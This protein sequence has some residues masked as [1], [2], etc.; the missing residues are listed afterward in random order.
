MEYKRLSF[1][2]AGSIDGSLCD[3]ILELGAASVSID[4]VDK[5][6]PWF[7]EYDVPFWEDIPDVHVTCLLDQ[8]I[9][10]ESFLQSVLDVVQWDKK[11]YYA[12]EPVI[13][14]SWEKI[15]RDDFDP[16]KINPS[17]WIVPTWHEPVDIQAVNIRLDPGLAF[18]SGSHATTRLCLQWLSENNL[19]DTHVLDFGCGSG[20]LAIASAMLGAHSVTATDTDDQAITS[21]KDNADL[22][23][24]CVTVIDDPN[25]VTAHFDIILANI[26]ARPLIAL[27]NRITELTR[28]GGRIVLSGIMQNQ[29]EDVRSAYDSMFNFDPLVV[30]G[31]WVLLSGINNVST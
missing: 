4:A 29:V 1:I 14:Q 8:N 24:V 3:L 25:I 5:D 15:G 22:N 13:E 23:Q 17:L 12:V 6:A 19:K 7:Q 18:G 9:S 31:D 20:I 28:P 10:P 21:T 16:I 26:L 2:P 30:S 11:P 27:S